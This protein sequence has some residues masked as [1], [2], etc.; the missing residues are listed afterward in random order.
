MS[1]N[2]VIGPYDDRNLDNPDFVWTSIERRLKALEEKIKPE[3]GPTPQPTGIGKGL[4]VV[5]NT[6]MVDYKDPV[7]AGSDLPASS[8]SLYR[9][10]EKAETIL[11][12]I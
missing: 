3:P 8:G 5:G 10:F 4:K 7:T 6:L 1:I 2:T 9:E 12:R 11:N